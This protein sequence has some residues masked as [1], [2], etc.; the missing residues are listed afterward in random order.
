MT[1]PGAE[2]WL[3]APAWIVFFVFVYWQFFDYSA[4]NPLGGPPMSISSIDPVGPVRAGE[5]ATI[6]YDWEILR[7]C[8]R[9]IELILESEN[10][11]IIV[12]RHAGTTSGTGIGTR[13]KDAVVLVPARWGE[14]PI[15][16][17]SLGEFRCNP[18]RSWRYVHETALQVER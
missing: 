7:D 18:L 8:P 12:R 15:I 10:E 9:S 13:H 2:I 5:Y 11:A 4:W 1:L 17:R 16:L 14:G 3:T 6:E